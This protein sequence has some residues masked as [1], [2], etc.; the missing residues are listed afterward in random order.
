DFEECYLRAEFERAKIAQSQKEATGEKL[1]RE[2][3]QRLQ[4]MVEALNRGLD[5]ADEHC[6][7][8]DVNQARLLL[9]YA[10]LALDEFYRAAV[11]GEDL[12]RTEPKFAQA[13]MAGAYA[14]SAYA[15]LVA[16]REKVGIAREELEVERQRQR[17]LAQYIEQTWPTSEAANIARH[18]LG[19]MSIA[20]K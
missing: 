5:L 3:R 10:Y 6:S 15:Q 13:S 17:R 12:V 2:R 9:T 18:V 1:E 11:A 14:L 16:E 4:N 19:D 7:I 8:E 20:D